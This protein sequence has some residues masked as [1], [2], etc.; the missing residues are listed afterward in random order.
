VIKLGQGPV[1]QGQ[2]GK[3]KVEQSITG[4]KDVKLNNVNGMIKI[5]NNNM[6]IG[7]C[8]KGPIVINGT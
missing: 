1:S 4:A 7:D 5:G 8:F 3:V 6:V 2:E